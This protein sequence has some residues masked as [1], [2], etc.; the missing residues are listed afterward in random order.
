MML[1]TDIHIGMNQL[2]YG[3]HLLAVINDKRYECLFF[4]EDETT[5]CRCEVLS[6]RK[7]LYL[8]H[9]IQL[10]DCYDLE[11]RDYDIVRQR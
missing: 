7:Y 6:Q 2:T 3:C 10:I 4:L 8:E 9:R 11:E 5:L 1:T